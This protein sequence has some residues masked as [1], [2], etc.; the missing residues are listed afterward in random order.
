MRKYNRVSKLTFRHLAA[1]ALFVSLASATIGKH[2]GYM[3]FGE[4]AIV[5]AVTALT[6]AVTSC[7]IILV[8]LHDQAQQNNSSTPPVP[9]AR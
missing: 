8:D 3:T 2:G 1:F 9:K 6:L 4:V 7:G 5:L